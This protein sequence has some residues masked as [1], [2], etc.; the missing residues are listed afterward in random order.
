MTKSGSPY[1]YLEYVHLHW[2]T[3][4]Y[5]LKATS[6]LK[7]K[8]QNLSKDAHTSTLL[9]EYLSASVSFLKLLFLNIMADSNDTSYE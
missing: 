3:Q 2:V 7:W 8:H 9:N 1:S 5:S 4:L 6:K